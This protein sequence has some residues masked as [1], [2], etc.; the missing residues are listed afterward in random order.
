MPSSTR[1]PTDRFCY[2]WQ[3]SS[4]FVRTLAAAFNCLTRQSSQLFVRLVND[5]QKL[6]TKTSEPPFATISRQ[7]SSILRGNKSTDKRIWLKPFHS[8]KLQT[9]T[10]EPSNFPAATVIGK[11]AS[12]FKLSHPSLGYQLRNKEN[13]FIF[14]VVALPEH[15]R[16]PNNTEKASDW[17]RPGTKIRTFCAP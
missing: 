8:H 17:T 10:S 16:L 2:I 12:I 14:R 13:W 15:A 6:Q 7:L 4:G 5:Y 1:Y 3:R 9:K 11:E